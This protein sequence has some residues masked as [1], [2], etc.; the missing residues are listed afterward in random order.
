MITILTLNSSTA[1]KREKFNGNL[2]K[3]DTSKVT[4]MYYSKSDGYEWM[5]TCDYCSNLNSLLPQRFTVP[6]GSCA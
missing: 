1:A 6:Q 2:S 3:W 4:T 5:V